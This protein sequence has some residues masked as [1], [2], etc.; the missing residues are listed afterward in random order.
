VSY[1][2]GLVVAGKYKLGH[3]LGTGGMADVYL[4][5]NLNTE[6]S[7]ALK[8]IPAGSARAEDRLH[9][10]QQEARATPRVRHAGIVPV[11]DAGRDGELFW[12]AMEALEGESLAQRIERG[13]LPVALV[14]SIFEQLLDVLDHVHRAEIVHRDLKPENIFLQGDQAEPRVRL[15]D[16]G[17]AKLRDESMGAGRTR[18]GVYMGTLGHVAP[19]QMRDARD[20]DARTDLYAVGVLLYQCLTGGLPYVAQSFAELA[21]KQHVEPPEP[22]PPL[23]DPCAQ[24]LGELALR[25]LAIEPE[26]RPESAAAV[27]ADVQRAREARDAR[28][29]ETLLSA[30]AAAQARTPWLVCLAAGPLIGIA[31]FYG[32]SRDAP[33]ARTSAAAPP[34]T[35]PA[36]S[37][38]Q[39]DARIDPVDVAVKTDIED[40]V[41][42]VDGESHGTAVDGRWQLRLWPGPHRLEARHRDSVVA[43]TLISLRPGV[44]ATVVLSLPAGAERSGR[45]A[46]SHAIGRSEPGRVLQA[47]PI[48]R[49]SGS[50]VLPPNH[51]VRA[52][53]PRLGAIR[54]CYDRELQ[55][56]QR[57]RGVL[58]LGLTIE[59]GGRISDVTTERDTTGTPEIADCVR[60]K[61]A[62]LVVRPPPKGGRVRVSYPLRFTP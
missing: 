17:I 56:D 40:G 54:T 2:A 18:S 12:L 26:Q 34:P 53:R 45:R 51:V 32:L 39:I 19:E 37:S 7:V 23:T 8:V 43:S 60:T 33:P 27:L 52:V 42:L 11:I 38:P 29:E 9:R 15:L 28:D 13:P 5:V 22:L 1:E 14:V 46:V 31:S 50:G 62:S 4:A 48:T 55:R 57:I 35:I 44:P 49:L 24:A 3:Q 61:L 59:P 36:P 30:K 47:G 20:V 21:A 58:T 41:L 25:C 10:F 6:R 16:F